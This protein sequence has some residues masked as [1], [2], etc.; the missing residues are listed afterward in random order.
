MRTAAQLIVKIL[1]SYDVKFIYG[2]PGAK[3]D[4]L[5]DALIDSNIR[6]ILCRHE[7]NAAFMAAA[8]GR[9]NG[10]PGVV[11]V[12]SGPG[13]SNMA[14]GLLTATT[15]GDP[16]VAIGGN[17][18][19]NMKYK[20]THQN[21]DNVNLMKPVC[22]SSVEV[23]EPENITE[24]FANAFRLAMAPKSGACFISLPQDILFKQVHETSKPI[25]IPEHKMGHALEKS[26]DEASEA[27][28]QAFKPVIL[29][30]LEASKYEN[31][32]ALN[33]FI[34]KLKIP[35]VNT[36]HATGVVIKD[37]LPYYVG[38]VG[39]FKNQPGDMLLDEADLIIT[40]GFDAVEYD[41]EIWCKPSHTIVHINYSQ[42][43][44]HNLYQPEYEV[45][46]NIQ[47][48]LRSL[49]VKITDVQSR[50][51]P[52]KYNRELFSIV[53]KS[54]SK[55]PLEGKIHPLRFIYELKKAVDEDTYI[56]CDIGS[57]YIW[58]A[59]YFYLHAPRHLLFSNGQ[60]TLGVALPWALAL[61]LDN[62][63]H[64]VLSISGDGGFL[65]SSMEL[66]TAKRYNIPLVHFI[67]SDGTYNMVKEQQLLKYNRECAV[68]LGAIDIVSYAKAFGMKGVEL[69]HP[70][71]IGTIIKKAFKEKS[72]ILINVPID[73]SDNQQLFTSLHD[74]ND[75]N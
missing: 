53:E 47:N 10:K 60:Q 36:Y 11:L 32:N 64:N 17:V 46:G 5:F 44:L 18:P 3:I 20:S 42:A 75:G 4:G 68:H 51:D 70:E 63:E 57:V 28:M 1:E 39:L 71:E 19:V 27:I 8:Y 52:S 13:V 33:A 65:F 48:N 59:R 7:Q 40:I 12:T 38:R 25:P 73:Y 22:K 9:H 37:L 43:T 16:V 72:Q 30:G 54:A 26:L 50:I 55:K 21:T 41:P 66:E 62:T 34:E 24:V 31:V 74:K 29:V 2:I 49:I 69:H 61:Q 56:C 67:W 45:I 14:T 6:L 23:S 58:L 15:E 35:I